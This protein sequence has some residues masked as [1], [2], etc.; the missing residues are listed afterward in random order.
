[1]IVQREHFNLLKR[2]V[3][4]MRALIYLLKDQMEPPELL[5]SAMQ[6]LGS[7]ESMK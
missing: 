2:Q 7:L 1:M 5:N 6:A 3:K 4:A